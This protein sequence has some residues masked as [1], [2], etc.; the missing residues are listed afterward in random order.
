MTGLGEAL[1]TVV[2][3]DVFRDVFLPSFTIA[4]AASVKWASRNDRYR[5][6][7]IEDIAVGLEVSLAAL[8]TFVG[9]SVNLARRVGTLSNSPGESALLREKLTTA[10]WI[11]LAFFFLLTLGS[12]GLRKW[13]WKSRH[14]VNAFGAFFPLTLGIAS[15]VL[16]V[17]WVIE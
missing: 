12:V 9:Y 11:L 7:A 3:S 2:T 8:L 5:T 13:G 14:E 1:A 10:P 17:L 4:V 16:A 15:E 6:F